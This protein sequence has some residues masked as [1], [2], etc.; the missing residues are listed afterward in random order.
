VHARRAV[1]ERARHLAH[2]SRAP[3][4]HVA[5]ERRALHQTLREARASATRRVRDER[6]ATRARA[7]ALARRAT[8]AAG[9]ELAARRT[10]LDGFTLALAA[11]DPERVIERGYA[12]VDDRHGNVLTSAE[13][14]RAARDVRL[15]FADA[16]VDARID[17]DG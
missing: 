13:A 2:L 17:D 9:P 6:A 5:R 10:A 14:A 1:I 15:R 11:H 7:S 4:E 8:V 16:A 12:V 3:G